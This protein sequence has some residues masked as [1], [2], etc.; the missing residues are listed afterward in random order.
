MN[1]KDLRF[2]Y[3]NGE[4]ECPEKYKGSVRECFWKMEQYIATELSE[5]DIATKYEQYARAKA[6]G[7]LEREKIGDWPN[8]LHFLALAKDVSEEEK[9]TGFCCRYA[10]DFSPADTYL[11]YF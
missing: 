2:R 6:D 1:K 11:E 3:Y 4:D 5:S 7:L 9:F 10:D 8:D